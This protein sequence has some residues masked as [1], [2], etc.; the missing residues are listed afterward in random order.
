MDHRKVG[1]LLTSVALVIFSCVLPFLPRAGPVTIG[2]HF[3]MGLTLGTGLAIMI[4]ALVKR[5]FGSQC[6][7]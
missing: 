1:L 4:S 3:I 6:E 7:R 2:A 5:R